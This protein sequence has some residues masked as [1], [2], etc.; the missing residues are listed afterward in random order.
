MG[1]ADSMASVSSND[2]NREGHDFGHFKL[3]KQQPCTRPPQIFTEHGAMMSGNVK[4]K[5]R[6]CGQ[7]YNEPIIGLCLEE[8]FFLLSL[9]PL[10]ERRPLSGYI[11]SY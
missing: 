6:E 2:R 3:K 1:R 7:H 5:V 4:P 10:L 8:I 9:F 11:D